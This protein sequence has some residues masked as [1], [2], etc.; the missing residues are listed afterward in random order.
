MRFVFRAILAAN[1]IEYSDYRLRKVWWVQTKRTG[2]CAACN[3]YSRRAHSTFRQTIMPN[4]EEG[5]MSIQCIL[6]QAL[7]PAID[8]ATRNTQFQ[9]PHFSPQNISILHATETTA[10]EPRFCCSCCCSG[11]TTLTLTIASMTVF[12]GK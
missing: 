12:G 8:V 6:R 4:R 7:I 10:G 9:F 5:S 1:F 2:E 3:Y 11:T